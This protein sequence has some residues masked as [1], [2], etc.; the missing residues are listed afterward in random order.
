MNTTEFL[1]IVLIILVNTNAFVTPVLA[2]VIHEGGAK[3]F[4]IQASLGNLTNRITR[5][6]LKHHKEQALA[7]HMLVCRTPIKTRC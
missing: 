3:L 6:S 2:P 7:V 5:F 4:P 1:R